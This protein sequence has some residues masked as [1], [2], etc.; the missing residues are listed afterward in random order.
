MSHDSEQVFYKI[1]EL[2]EMLGVESSV[3]RFWEKEFPQIKPMKVGQRK[4][5][6]RRKDFEVFQE[7]KRLLYDERF[8][9][10]GAKK[11]LDRAD[12]RQGDLFEND[13]KISSL[14]LFEDKR[15][16]ESDQLRTARAKID[17]ARKG[18]LQIREILTKGR[19]VSPSPPAK[20]KR[21]ASAKKK[22]DKTSDKTMD[23]INNA[24][25]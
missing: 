17:E 14:P 4:R 19:T 8:T 3:L 20:P 25:E 15:E 21:K 1:S 22:S 9:I 10:A 12:S 24:S 2:S 16:A 6:Y 18:L 11:R 23:L 13:D 5:L 7:I